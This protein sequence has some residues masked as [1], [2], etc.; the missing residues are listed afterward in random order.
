MTVVTGA[1]SRD[2][3]LRSSTQILKSLLTEETPKEAG[4]IPTLTAP[5]FDPDQDF[6]ANL[7]RMVMDLRA[8]REGAVARA[9]AAS[10]QSGPRT[11]TIARAD[12]GKVYGSAGNDRFTLSGNRIDYVSAGA[13]NDVI[14]VEAKTSSTAKDG[15]ASLD[16][17]SATRIHGGAGND[18]ITVHADQL[19]DTVYGGD[20]DDELDVAAS[21]ASEIAGGE[22]NDK[23]TVSAHVVEHVDGNGGDDEITITATVDDSLD[24]ILKDTTG[25]GRVKDVTGG[26]GDDR[27]TVKA[28][29]WVT[30][31]DAGRG[32]DSLD[33]TS[34]E[35]I[36]DVLSGSGDDRVKLSAGEK[37][38]HVDLGSGDDA[39]DL[40]AKRISD[41]YGGYGDDDMSLTGEFITDVHGGSGND[42][43]TITGGP[44]KSG[45]PSVYAV[46]GGVGDDKITIT[47]DSIDYVGGDK[48]DDT[49]VLRARDGKNPIEI[50]FAE[51]DGHDTIISTNDLAIW[52]YSADATKEIGLKDASLTKSGTDTWELTFKGSRDRITLVHSEPGMASGTHVPVIDGN[53]IRWKPDPS[54]K[55]AK[56]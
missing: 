2:S 31:I 45:I 44:S 53:T 26:F 35:W 51:G 17:G 30:E 19:V 25:S 48:G 21:Y 55:P 47:A 40:K 50:R 28:D 13:G 52:R 12:I 32:D 49:L 20:G 7:A 4:R 42:T 15:L 56:A 54:Y 24:Q 8:S 22:G 23:V 37:V 43:I 3:M 41:V 39:L 10:S 9:A 18:Q 1:S 38:R 46:G 34:R 29:G 27:I 36:A 5:G 14:A 11:V 6:I 33:I 16:S